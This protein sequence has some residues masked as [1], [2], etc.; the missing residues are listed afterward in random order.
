MEEPLWV[1][2][3]TVS[4]FFAVYTAEFIYAK[5]NPHVVKFREAAI[6]VVVYISAAILFGIGIWLVK[7][8]ASG[9]E[10][11]A[12]WITEYSLSVDNLFVF[13]IILSAFAVPA[14]YQQEVLQ[15]GIIGALVLRF[16]FIIVGATAIAKFS[17]IF[18]LFGAFLLYTAYKLASNHGTE[19]DPSQNK[20]LKLAEK[21][22]PVTPKYHEGAFRVKI[23][24]KKYFTPLFVVMIAIF[25]TDILFALDSIPAIFGLTEDPYIVFT[26]NA[27]ALMG[28]RQMYF[29]LDGLLDRLIY[30]SYGLS[31]I[32]GFIGIKLI[33]HA[34]HE[35]G[36]ESAPEITTPISLAVIIGVLAITVFASLRQTKLHPELAHK[37]GQKAAGSAIAD[38]KR[39]HPDVEQA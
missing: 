32:L 19:S 23:D 26:A 12:G 10:F 39:D 18:F 24:G 15:V 13:V 4:A 17:W 7:G 38:I 29:M 11:F 22:L 3:V 25:T 31:V 9:V 2:I 16:L 37:P 27:F 33:L 30:L 35:N 1:W 8:Q 14:I 34:A 6:W 20:V 36:F 5:K 28:L 21:Y